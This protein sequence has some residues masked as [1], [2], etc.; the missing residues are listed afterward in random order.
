MAKWLD[1]IA[2][3]LGYAPRRGRRDFAAA[4]FDRLTGGW[5]STNASANA[6]LF[7]ALDTLRAR[8]RDLCNN[9]D[10]AKRFVGMVAANV[11]G[12]TGFT[13]QARVYDKPG[14][15]DS[16]ANDAI[17][18]AWARWCKRGTCDVTGR[19]SFRDLQILIAK[20]VARDGECL[21]RRVRGK[22]AG[23]AF[24]YALQVIDIDRLD[25]RLI[26][27]AEGNK[28]EIRMGVEVDAFGKSVAYWLRGYH[29]GDTYGIAAGAVQAAHQRV[30][31]GEIL[32]IYQADRPEQLRGLPWMH[33]AMTRL[34]NLGGYEE[35]AVIA[36]RVGAAKMGF[37][38]SPDGQPPMDGEDAQGV[39]YLEA[40]AGSF[41][42]LPAGVDFK[43]FDP[44]YP[45]AM[46]ADFVKACLRGIASGLGVAYHALAND[47]EG[48]NFSSIRSGTL[49]ERDQW[50][51]L[52]EWFKDAFMEPV[53]DDWLASAL[54]FGQVTLANGSPLPASKAEKFTGHV[55]QG[56][57]W[58]WVDPLKDMNA[59]IIAIQNGLQS[60]QSVA[61]ELG[62]DYE[63]V[64]V[65][66]RQAQ[67]LAGK[68]GVTIG[69]PAPVKDSPEEE[70][71]ETKALAAVTGEVRSLR[72]RIDAPPPDTGLRDLLAAIANGQEQTAQMFA[73]V[74]ARQP[75][76]TKVDVHNHIAAPDPT[77]VEIRNEIHE[78]EQ[79]API[80][81]VEVEA[82]MPAQEAPQVEVHVEAVMPDEIRT[83]IVSQPERVTTTE[84]TRDTLGNIKTSKQTE[85]DA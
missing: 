67:D 68:L 46:Y 74:M 2:S 20:A 10:Y 72:E 22:S 47:L 12:G 70:S 48:V 7:R 17:E 59:K 14:V 15:P 16:G 81:N 8:S 62:V 54:A 35:A 11:V 28:N 49:E 58:S 33:A 4:R 51:S 61:A 36:C 45:S 27:P 57:R 85:K 84:I 53:F 80:V 24:G 56:R 65:Q 44:D 30:P 40:D 9:N 21:V 76:P 50:I 83:A 38:T 82:V 6:D 32:H 64:L 19:L 52:Q 34:N 78:R 5:N 60:P 66:I 75:E 77:P 79:A 13:L 37:F 71:A 42:V 26:Q 41:G 31:A 23:N 29:P 43:P 1:T 3:R 39:P 55:F 25:T 69:A 18:Q 63:D 73:A